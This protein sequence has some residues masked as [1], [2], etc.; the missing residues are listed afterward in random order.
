MSREDVTEFFVME[1]FPDSVMGSGNTRRL[2]G[3][4]GMTLE[5]AW[6]LWF[7]KAE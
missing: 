2:S 7:G 6:Y 5:L 4:L 1:K 3:L